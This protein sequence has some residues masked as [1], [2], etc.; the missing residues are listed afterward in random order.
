MYW[1]Q[2]KEETYA[3]EQSNH[4]DLSI[5]LS[6]MLTHNILQT[7]YSSEEIK[8]KWCQWTLH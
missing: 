1:K 2:E 8:E 6:K 7:V 5:A 4:I 3:L